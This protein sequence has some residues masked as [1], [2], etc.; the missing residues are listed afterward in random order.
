MSFY[1]LLNKNRT[2]YYRYLIN[3]AL[4]RAL[5]SLNRLEIP[6]LQCYFLRYTYNYLA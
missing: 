4:I 6:L 3:S 2:I 5:F 1:F